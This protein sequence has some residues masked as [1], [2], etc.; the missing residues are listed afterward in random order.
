MV[1]L[2][3]VYSIEARFGES[4]VSVAARAKNPRLSPLTGLLYTVAFQGDPDFPTAIKAITKAFKLSELGVAFIIHDT[5]PL[6][7]VEPETVQGDLYQGLKILQELLKPRVPRTALVY[8]TRRAG[9]RW[10]IQMLIL[11]G[12]LSR[13]EIGAVS[14]AVATSGAT[15]TRVIQSTKLQADVF[16]ITIFARDDRARRGFLYSLQGSCGIF[17]TLQDR[18]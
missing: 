13:K 1:A 5:D 6:L 4:I 7:T 10:E 3:R 16:C 9:N 12:F 18:P 14:R 17:A 8:E 15:V 11:G 2:P